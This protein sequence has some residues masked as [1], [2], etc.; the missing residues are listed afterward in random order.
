MT[1]KPEPLTE[2]E[3]REYRADWEGD[4]QGMA[5][6]WAL[7]LFAT[8]DATRAA[9]SKA[10]ATIAAAKAFH[11][12][13]IADVTF[14]EV[15]AWLRDGGPDPFHKDCR[16][17]LA[18][19]TDR[20]NAHASQLQRIHKPGCSCLGEHAACDCGAS[21]L[22]RALEAATE[23]AER[24]EA[25]RQD[26]AWSAEEHKNRAES[27]LRERDAARRDA[28]RCLEALDSISHDY[29][30]GECRYCGVKRPRGHESDCKIGIALSTP[31][32]GGE[33]G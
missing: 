19:A 3:E 16:A 28:V 5:R 20:A 2:A 32:S 1:T 29:K 7:R 33:N 18:A 4:S 22:A 27:A 26:A 13:T 21:D 9:L 15:T 17:Q 23:R 11:E 30:T 12:K 14:E 31:S 10:N 8:L 24:A 25:E 6:T